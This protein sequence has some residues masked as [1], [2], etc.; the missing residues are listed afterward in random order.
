MMEGNAAATM[1]T[2]TQLL[3]VFGV[4]LAAGAISAFIAQRLRLPDIVLFMLTGIALGPQA[5]G[6]IDIPVSSVLNQLILIFGA[7]FIIFDGGASLRFKV[8]K[9]VWITLALIAT[10]GVVITMV[11]T[12]VAAQYA[13]GVSLIT[14]LLLGAAIASTDPATLIPVF[15]QVRIRDR[16]TQTVVSESGLND[17]TGAIITLGLLGMALGTESFSVGGALFS[18]L[19]EAGMGLLV[20]GVIGYLAILFIAHERLG[21]LRE[22]LPLVALLVVISGYLSAMN[23][24]GSGFMAAL[25]AGL[26]VGNR[27]SFGYPLEHGENEKL[28]EFVET[29]ALLV[30]I[31]IFILLGSQV[32]FALLKQYL[33]GSLI[34]VAVFM[35]VARPLTVFA[36]AG[37]DRRARWSLRELLFMCWTRETGVIPAALAG[38]L[39]GMNVPG[40]DIIAAVT[41]MAILLTIVVQASTT[42][43]LAQK[44][45]VLV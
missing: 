36:C 20:G 33:G 43:W 2:V 30:R 10:V 24:H 27:A 37:I 8:L 45:G 41:F 39:Q 9:Q 17:A 15:R 31:F 35:L 18:L 42:R 11:V 44:L 25:V 13:L 4:I 1:E 40:A 32:D 5:L 22:H 3:F 6:V 16:V 38:M 23:F 21:F 29:T 19:R 34:V 26:F 7:S 12:A 28:A 14:A